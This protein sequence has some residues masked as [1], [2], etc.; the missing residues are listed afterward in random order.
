MGPLIPLSHSPPIE[1]FNSFLFL[2]RCKTVLKIGG[3]WRIQLEG[4][5]FMFPYLFFF[6]LKDYTTS[7]TSRFAS[8]YV[9]LFLLSLSLFL[10]SIFTQFFSFPSLSLADFSLGATFLIQATYQQ[11]RMHVRIIYDSNIIVNTKSN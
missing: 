4:S 9:I 2:F 5:F 7:T 11:K 3:N 10:H 8:A 1:S 6:I